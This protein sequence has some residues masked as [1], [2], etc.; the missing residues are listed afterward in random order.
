LQTPLMLLGRLLS[1][2]PLAASLTSTLLW[3]PLKAYFNPHQHHLMN[4]QVTE[5]KIIWPTGRNFQGATAL[6][7]FL[8]LSPLP[9]LRGI[10]SVPDPR[11]R[12]FPNPSEQSPT[13]INSGIASLRAANEN[14][15]TSLHQV[16]D[17][18]TIYIYIYPNAQPLDLD[19]DYLARETILPTLPTLPDMYLFHFT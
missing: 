2:R 8:A 1:V 19:L 13:D 9:D 3:M 17:Y 4:Q 16:Y 12:Y 14:V 5:Q 10:P 11:E 18:T 15:V 7:P 6:G